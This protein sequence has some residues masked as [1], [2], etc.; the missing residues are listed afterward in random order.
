MIEHLDK[1]PQPLQMVSE[2]EQA[3]Q[4]VR[5]ALIELYAAV[6]AD[7]A[8]PQE[9][10][11]R[12]GLNRVLT[13]KLSRVI[14]AQHAFASLSHLPGPQGFDLATRAFKRGGAPAAALE[15]VEQ[16]IR[17]FQDVVARHADDR[18]QFELTLES[19]GLFERESR[20]EGGRELAYRGNSMIWGVQARTRAAIAMCA[21]SASAAHAFDVVQIGV[22]AGFRRLRPS[23][24][25]RLFRLQMHDD[26]GGNI[27]KLKLPE[28]LV[29]KSEG[30]TPLILREFCSPN[31]PELEMSTGPEGVEFLL[32]SGPV[33]N[34]AA[35]DSCFAYVAR[36]L[37]ALRTPD[38]EYASFGCAI[39][40][41]VETLVFDLILHRDVRIASR[42]E[43]LVYGF[44]HGGIDS[45]QAQ[46]VQN[47]LPI[48]REP[49]ELP[50]SPPAVATPLVPRYSQLAARVYERMKWNPADF[51]GIRVQ[52]PYPPMSSRAVLRWRL[53]ESPPAS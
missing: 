15:H 33:G 34:Q 5:R 49:V 13:W 48:T 44:P 20:L 38:N 53:P 25:W 52:I 35:F 18:D 45:P 21:P 11:R 50:G 36:G 51:R 6:E 17:H 4:N 32:P 30:D 39:T 7:P 3:L 29:P 47:L 42:L 24:R 31:M 19:M 9:V 41:P 1:Q 16:A 10:A 26:A 27:L 8:N 46:T 22:L 12:F 2:S 43:M 28:E 40:L 23:A 37:P 14:G